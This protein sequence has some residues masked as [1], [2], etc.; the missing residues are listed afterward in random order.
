MSD[1][2]PKDVAVALQSA[3]RMTGSLASMLENP[4]TSELNQRVTIIQLD[5]DVDV[6]VALL[7]RMKQRVGG[8]I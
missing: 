4:N 6:I 2:R 3:I 8:E 1:I 7:D 5:E